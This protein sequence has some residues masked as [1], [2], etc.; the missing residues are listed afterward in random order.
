M[1]ASHGLGKPSLPAAHSDRV[2]P[3]RGLGA[4]AERRHVAELRAA[5]TAQA[6]TARAEQKA[7]WPA[8]ADATGALT[9]GQALHLEA[10]GLPVT[11]ERTTTHPASGQ[12]RLHVVG[13]A[14]AQAA[15]VDGVLLS[16]TAD[17][18]GTA[19]VS[20]NYASFA[21]AYGGG[22][23]GRLRLVQLPACA[24]TTP[25]RPACRT[26]TP[27]K[28]SN[29]PVRQTVTAEVALNSA[30][31]TSAV[32]GPATVMAV[33]AGAGEAASGG[34]NYS[35]SPLSPSFTWAAGNSSGSFTWS[36]P[37]TTP[38]AAA[39]PAPDLSL[40]Y[41]SGSIDGRTASTNN[42]GSQVGEG[43]DLSTSSYVERSYASC[44]D[45][46]ET[47]KYDECWKYDNASLVLNGKSTELVKDDATGTW[48]LKDDDAS[49]V[50]HS[51][52]AAN[53][54]EGDSGVDGA[55]EYWTVTTGDGTRYVFGLNKL[56]GAGTERTNSVWTTPVFGNN[57]GEPGY[58]DGT[59]FSGRS[60]TQ[61][62]RWN[63]DYVVDLHGNAMTYW[64]TP[65][66][67]SYGKNGAT[68]GTA[69]YTRGGYLDH[70]LYGQ[71][72]DALFTGTA[73]D[74]VQFTYSE[75]CTASDC[76]SLTKD[77][78]PNWPDV[79]FDS[80][81]ASGATCHAVSPT[82]F[83][84]KRLTKVET[85]AWNAA[86]SPAAYAPAD[87]YAFDQQYLDPG[88]IGN[89]TDQTLV[90]ST[91]R[92]IG[93]NGGTLALDPVTFQYQMRPNRVDAPT[94]DVL[95]L[96]RPRI[97]SVTSETGSITTVTLS[98]PEC[99]RGSSMPAA[100][101][102][103]TTSCYP[104]YWHVNGAD[105]A[106]LDW[107]HKYRVT[108]VEVADPTG[109]GESMETTYAYSGPA[110][111]YNDDPFTPAKERTWS[112]WRGYHTV[113]T[114]T[115]SAAG[116]QS[117]TTTVYLQGM[118]GDRQKNGT[119]RS[120]SAAG[121]G[122]TGLSVPGVTDSDQYQGF[123]RE[124]ITYN[125]TTPVSV[126]V[127]DPYSARTA[128]QQ[129]SYA[130]VDAYYVRT[131]RTQT[132]TYLTASGGWRTGSYSTTYDGYGM[133]VELDDAGQVGVSGDESCTRTWYARNTA[134]GVTA[135]VSRT[136][137]TSRACST[138]ETDLNLPTTSATR[139]DVL[140]DTATVYDNTSATTWTPAQT[141][142]L[143]EATWTGRAA[144]YPAT[145][146][147]GER[148]PTT[149]Q[150]LTK[151]TYDDTTAKLGRVLSTTDAAGNST[152]TAYVPAATGPATR[153]QVT[154]AKSQITYT[155]LDFARGSTL[156][157]YDVNGRITESAYDPL[158]RVTSLWLPNQSRVDGYGANST[159]SYHL[160]STAPSYVATSSIIAEGSYNTSYQIYDSLLR[161]LQT[162]TPTPNGG[163]LLS[164][165]R[166][167]GRGLVS[168]SYSDVFDSTTTPDGTYTRAESGRA[169]KQTDTVFDGA[170]RPTT[171]RFLIYGVQKWSTTTSYTGD[172]TATS[173]PDGGSATRTITDVFG[174]T[175]EQ[176]E[177]AGTTP[178][179]T[180]YGSGVGIPYTTTDF[181]YTRD[182]K[183]KTV[184]GPDTT[185]SYTYDLFGRQV[186]ATDPDKGTTN[187]SYTA[188]DQI[189]TTTDA[190]NTTLLYDYDVLGRKTDLWQ[191]SRTD[192]NK[193]GLWTYDG[194]LKGQLDS[195]TSYVGGTTG[196]AYTEKVTAFDTMSRPTKTELDLPATD[197]L[198]T[199]GAV[200]AKLVTST[201]YNKDGT[202]QFVDDPAAGGLPS[203]DVVTH[204]NT[205]GLPTDVQGASGYLLSATY[206]NLSQPQQLTL[207]TSPSEGVLKAYVTNT[208]EEGTDR[209][210]ASVVTDQTHPY[211]DQNLSY[212][213]DTAGNVTHTFDPTTLG[214]TAQADN[215]CYTYDG[216][217]RLTDAWTPTTPDCSTTGR[218]TGNLGG[219][220]PYWTSYTYNDAG[221]RTTQTDHTPA[222]STL[223]TYCYDPARPHALTSVLTAAATCTGTPAA[224]AYD[225]DGNTTT[226]PDGTDTQTLTWTSQG[227]LDTLTEKTSTGTVTGTTSHV[228]DADGNLLIRRGTTDDTVL[229]LGD[230]EVHLATGTTPKY[231][232]Q[233]YYGAAG[234]TLA[235]RSNQTG[236]NTLT[237]L[238]G[239]Q[240]GTGTLAI[241]ATTQALTKRYTTPFG[242]P[243]DGTT[244]TWP[245]DNGF[246]G[247]PT[248]G[249]TGLTYIGA[250]QYDPTTGR[251]MSVDPVLDTG[252][253]QSLNGYT[254][255]DNN[256][257]TLSDPS[258]LRPIGAGNG[259]Y[260][261]DQY[262]ASHNAYWTNTA[263]G[264]WT[265]NQVSQTEDKKHV[266]VGV[267]S[268]PTYGPNVVYGATFK[269]PKKK[270]S[271]PVKNFFGGVA[272]SIV[273]SIPSPAA[274]LADA[275]NELSLGMTGGH[276][277]KAAPDMPIYPFG[278]PDFLGVDADS[279][280]YKLGELTGLAAQMLAGP[281]GEEKTG[282]SLVSKLL[283]KFRS[284]GCSFDGETP[285]LLADGES[286]PISQ[287]HPGDKVEAGSAENGRRQG[288]RTVT[289]TFINHDDDLI[290]LQIETPSGRSATLHTTAQHPF[291]DDTAHAWA[292][293][294]QL[295]P[296]HALETAQNSHARVV[297]VHVIAGAADMYNLSVDQLHTYYV[298]A[299]G[300]PVLVHNTGAGPAV[301]FRGARPGDSPTFV[302]RPN[303]YKVDPATGFVKGTHG[304]SVFD[305]PE[306]VAGKGFVPHEVD[307][308]TVPDSL[309]IIQRGND[310]RHFEI[311]PAP[312]AN[313]TPQQYTDALAQ[314]RT[315]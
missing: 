242:A 232:A 129:K 17:G 258:G 161:P 120:V 277:G 102:D 304:L 43:F 31:A 78:A 180:D 57:A 76:S 284:G 262:N 208:W 25:A 200:A 204:H 118:D 265:Y 233:R 97:A 272:D 7:A 255:A 158:G 137:A 217:Q 4:T 210:L 140:S 133:A 106:T 269:K 282:G 9:T 107:F 313:L 52:G 19:R 96:N 253:S 301:C 73:S 29:D 117:K 93:E 65:E 178:A 197:P 203:E 223:T 199:S 61:A 213:Y 121:I 186:S 1:A 50:T 184:T 135:L 100:E 222:T 187:T 51:T 77:T 311:V 298:L 296:G 218:T 138:T 182:G 266:F 303:D 268:I 143:G 139:G 283:S 35:A 13:Q 114:T 113:T 250:R 174:R 142:T 259:G 166:Y 11:I 49:T 300:T 267:V 252:D 230:T 38:P 125:G 37:M 95:P 84:R 275:M 80:I 274:A 18:T 206:T 177:Y 261:S 46:G 5:N 307:M 116:T 163:R 30:S 281:A 98:N 305:N 94:D 26:Q 214:G 168:E 312:G 188:L 231:W 63:L 308:G 228:Y 225:P 74:K 235:L 310:P 175:V 128:S 239:D 59:A 171:S 160:S 39:G 273:G 119:T 248:D 75:R 79:P 170:G 134:I 33:A 287:I 157:A 127:S 20:V 196:T 156:K 226:R 176:R 278:D 219:A 315:R 216:H 224:Y 92:H 227:Q 8:A 285:V 15:G 279:S 112:Q 169:P 99:V 69:T 291:W 141:P 245:D 67:N 149:W 131:A 16:A 190:R 220:S 24:L 288:G 249:T 194:V 302:P 111:H 82:F 87:A 263:S 70:I 126:T 229:Y 32:A 193:L 241:D 209:L 136:R 271:N 151:T 276:A 54:D 280:A 10:G 309:R 122:F 192:A 89:S 91:I 247:K 58:A 81:C 236:T 179:D 150:T 115:G 86:A 205:L 27:L 148:N 243:R 198:V 47:G 215:E 53:G 36:Y 109:H 145:A 90:L 264:G 164:D 124:E 104:V 306:S 270:S 152:K 144:A 191:T 297:A 22:W 146:T 66:T 299:A 14:Q 189:D 212:G 201:A 257:A 110:W 289:A 48:R 234:V 202:Q 62:W 254:Y 45:D 68:T 55:G 211:Q 292:P 185:W 181:T 41:D 244:G 172:S 290:D 108:A 105:E 183:Q 159:Y 72:S 60:L 155:Y 44:D 23:A 130:D 42:Q 238:A 173:A 101:D 34:G 40:T 83:T 3:V 123:T 71:R 294:G 295:T 162:Q 153:V 132:S 2:D 195:S 6:K 85:F 28:S 256:P 167:D 12:M 314:I 21:S 260:D 64:Y 246:L 147:N 154:N 56:P 240:H 165:T 251:F 221:L 293:A 88:D 103:D 237:W 286:R 207:G